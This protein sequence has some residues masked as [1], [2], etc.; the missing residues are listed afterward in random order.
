MKFPLIIAIFA[1]L[2]PTS[3][4]MDQPSFHTKGAPTGKPTGP[5]SPEFA[6]KVTAEIAPGTTVIMT[7]RA[8]HSR[9]QP[10]FYATNSMPWRSGFRR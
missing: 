4:A 6:H 9:T 7:D 5:F 10:Q 8:T 1:A 3:F 2:V